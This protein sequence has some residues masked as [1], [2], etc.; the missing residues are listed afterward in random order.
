MDEGYLTSLF[1]LAGKVAIV[2]GGNGGLGLGM[3]EGLA[4]AGA[5]IAIAARSEA[6]ARAAIE[7]LAGFGTRVMFVGT[8]VASKQ[9][10]FDMA[11]AVAERFGGIDILIANAGMSKAGRAETLSEQDWRRTIDINLSGTLFSAQAVF[12][13]MAARGGGKIVT[14]ASL[15]SLFGA[16]GNIDYAASKGGCIQLTKSLA[17][18]WARRNIQVNAIIPGWYETEITN[19]ARDGVEGFHESV[20]R[21]TPARRWGKPDDLAGLAVF[22]SSSASNFMTGASLVAD[23]GYSVV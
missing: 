15:L 21:R 5:D 3:A 8:D 12:P 10:C 23:G 13:H 22:L 16:A 20:V 11:D 7:H 19:E 4:R 2:T 6:K 9:S 17:A 18:A 14:V 1:G